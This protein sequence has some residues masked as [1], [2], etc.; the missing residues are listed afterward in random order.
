MRLTI[1]FILSSTSCAQN[2]LISWWR[3]TFKAAIHIQRSPD[4]KGGAGGN[5][6]PVS[7]AGPQGRQVKGKS[8]TVRFSKGTFSSKNFWFLPIT[9]NF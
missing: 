2:S 6:A 4:R 5:E 3:P 7:D 1:S 9:L 8:A